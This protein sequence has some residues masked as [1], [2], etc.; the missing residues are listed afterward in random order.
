MQVLLFKKHVSKGC[1]RKD[2]D[3]S[4]GPGEKSIGNLHGGVTILEALRKVCDSWKE[5]KIPS[6]TGVGKKLILTLMDGFE[7]FKTSVEDATA[8]VETA[9]ELEFEA[10][11]EDVAESPQSRDKTLRAEEWLF[12]AE[13]RKRFLQ[14][15]SAPGEGAMNIAE[16]P[17]TE[18]CQ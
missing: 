8:N 15:E 17:I 14:V 4:H 12:K 5:V 18:K 6:L 7:D 11:P 16:I 2:S 10:G 3:S 9:R 1:S 13:Q